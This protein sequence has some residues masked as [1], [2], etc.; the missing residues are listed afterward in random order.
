MKKNVVLIFVIIIIFIDTLQAVFLNISPFL[1]FKDVKDNSSWVD[2]GIL[3]DT[4][5]CKEKNNITI[6][7]RK[8]KFTKF[9][10]FINNDA[11]LNEVENVMMNIKEDTLTNVGAIVIITD[12]SYKD[13]IYDEAYAIEKKEN[14]KW[15]E[16]DIIGDYAFLSKIYKINANRKLEFSHN[17][18]N[19][20]GELKTGEYRL[21]KAVFSNE[22]VRK[23]ISVEFKIN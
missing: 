21:V 10:C 22:G 13:Y 5:Y 11:E 16:L 3:I 6:I 1:S 12:Y 9:S 23:F 14:G 17:W 18:F 7:H 20:Y 8:L 15:I 2:K 4:Y 19:M